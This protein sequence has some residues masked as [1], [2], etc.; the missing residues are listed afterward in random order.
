M[1]AR[2]VIATAP[3]H[4]LDEIIALWHAEVLPSVQQQP[5]YKGV[6]FLVDRQT[7]KIITMGLWESAAAFRATVDWNKG[8][9]D[10]FVAL[11]SE[12]PQVG[13]YTVVADM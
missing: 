12:P 10:K 2:V 6:R 4:K 7:G 8:Q 1:Y 13:G 9:V 11:F 5:G 3:P